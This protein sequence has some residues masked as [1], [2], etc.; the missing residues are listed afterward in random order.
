MHVQNEIIYVMQDR[1]LDQSR[2]DKFI[3][4]VKILEEE[5]RKK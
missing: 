3:K 1:V 4:T 5:K 2:E